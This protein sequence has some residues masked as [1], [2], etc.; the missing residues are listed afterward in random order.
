MGA[1]YVKDGKNL[2]KILEDE[3]VT[4]WRRDPSVKYSFKQLEWGF[5]EGNSKPQ[6][7]C[8]DCGVFL[9][10][11][12]MLFTMKHQFPLPITTTTAPYFRDFLSYFCS[13]ECGF[14]QMGNCPLCS[15]WY[16]GTSEGK[17]FICEL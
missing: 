1:T 14:K 16:T 3:F 4:H 8:Y 17:Y 11:H 2:L 15:N 10:A 7:N 9:C 6:M 12:M 13:E 5:V